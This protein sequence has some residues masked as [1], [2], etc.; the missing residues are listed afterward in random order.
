MRQGGHRRSIIRAV[1]EALER[2]LFLTSVATFGANPDDALDDT[3]QIINAINATSD[4]LLQ[5]PG[6]ASASGGYL[7]SSQLPFRGQINYDGTG[8]RRAVL[9]ASPTFQGEFLGAFAGA[10]ASGNTS[11]SPVVLQDLTF[12]GFGVNI[13]DDSKW[14]NIHDCTFQ[15]MLADRGNTSI[16]RSGDKMSNTT[17]ED[18]TFFNAPLYTGISAYNVSNFT[19]SGNTFDNVYQ[20]LH[21][22]SDLPDTGSFIHVADNTFTRI[23]R[24]GVEIQGGEHPIPPTGVLIENNKLSRFR[25]HN[26][27]TYALSIVSV[28]SGTIVRNNEVS[29]PE[30]VNHR[31]ELEYGIEISGINPIIEDNKLYGGMH[32]AIAVGFIGG[33]LNVRRNTVLYTPGEGDVFLGGAG[34]ITL[35]TGVDANHFITMLPN[36]A[37]VVA[38]DLYVGGTN[39]AETLHVFP[40]LGGTPPLV[41]VSVTGVPGGPV[42]KDISPTGRIFL[43]GYDGDDSLQ[44]SK[45]LMEGAWLDGGSGADSLYGGSGDD[46]LNGGPGND[47]IAG[48]IDG[49]DMLDFSGTASAVSANLVTNVVSGGAGAD[50]LFDGGNISDVRGGFGNDTVV[51]DEGNNKLYGGDGDDSLSGG[52]GNDLLNGGDDLNGSKRP[53]G[54]DAEGQDILDGGAGSDTVSYAGREEG[55]DY[56]HN[57]D[58]LGDVKIFLNATMA[59]QTLGDVNGTGTLVAEDTISNFENATG[60]FGSDFIRGTTIANVLIGG[61]GHNSADTVSYDDHTAAVTVNLNA[62]TAGVGG[63]EDTISGFENATGGS[64]ADMLIGTPDNNALDGG[65]GNDTLYGGAGDDGELGGAGD[66]L[67]V[68]E[69]GNDNL[70]GQDGIDYHDCGSGNDT[71]RGGAGKDAAV[72]GDG[73]DSLVGEAD[74]DNLQGQAGDDIIEGRD[75]TDSLR[76]DAGNDHIKGGNDNDTMFGGLDSDWLEGESGNDTLYDNSGSGSDGVPDT[77]DGGAGTDSSPIHD[78]PKIDELLNIP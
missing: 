24:I 14:F 52:S 27:S 26:G 7:I 62:A 68:G 11:G 17:V 47:F 54:I 73:N 56:D 45:D 31:G 20:G 63:T 39:S 75:G 18:C 3:A 25:N 4:G 44:I 66:D 13:G 61:H 46:T 22:I 76:G 70:Q 23:E 6:A 32:S 74:N 35:G 59:T 33:T 60:G 10:N 51:G 28:A 53:F 55:H 30:V 57:I 12:N 77:L 64:G 72:G 21:F 19:A 29:E 1:D 43:Y 69:D 34:S 38:G 50:T 40:L 9:K 8:A 37:D 15:N 65:G 5:F 71:V 49:F 67:L 48:G 16:I 2:R 36:A 58:Y 78:P 42:T 41:H